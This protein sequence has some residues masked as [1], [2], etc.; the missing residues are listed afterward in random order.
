MSHIEQLSQRLARP[1]GIRRLGQALWMMVDGPVRRD[2]LLWARGLLGPDGD[3]LLWDTLI[4]IGALR[5]EGAKLEPGPVARLL[6]LMWVP[7]H[8][9]D[10]RAPLVWTLPHQLKM[11]ER[12]DSYV[13]AA[14]AVIDSAKQR[15]ILVSPFLE[16]AGVG[17]LLE[18]LTACLYRRVSVTLITH[19]AETLSSF[20]STAL[21]DLRR[22]STGLAASL[23]VYSVD[24]A[25]GLLV[26]SKLVIADAARMVLGSANLTSRGLSTNFE[27]GVMLGREAA[28]EA[29]AVVEALLASGL[30]SETFKTA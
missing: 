24:D 14:Q 1:E 13:K 23:T 26:H 17:H 10:T 27:A 2:E 5:P 28:T 25:C 6:C 21:N 30:T 3:Q 15:V 22:A 11:P 16:A 7:E 9:D 19:G 4:E 20:A 12:E 8:Q 18:S 29:S